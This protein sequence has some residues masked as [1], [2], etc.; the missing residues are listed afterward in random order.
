MSLLATLGG[1]AL[2]AAG[3]ILNNERNLAFQR[4]AQD[5]NKQAQHITWAREDT[6]VRRRRA[7]LEAAGLSPVLAAGSAAQAGSPIKIDPQV[8]QD[9]FGTEA[10]ISGAT[11]AA[12]TQQSLFAA[13]AA[14]SVAELN[15][16]NI[17]KVAAETDKSSAQ[18]GVLRK[19]FN[20]YDRPT[21][22]PK[23]ED[24]WGKRL[25]GLGELFRKA[26]PRFTPNKTIDGKPAMRKGLLDYQKDSLMPTFNW[27]GIFD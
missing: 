6:A 10:G 5:W 20:L 25:S 8:S 24:Q 12:Q 13:D 21:G 9:G 22:H 26:Q 2:G 23:Y 16:A 7:D 4:E 17:L 19:E 27:G 18:A 3:G 1:A 11:R 15:R 14:K